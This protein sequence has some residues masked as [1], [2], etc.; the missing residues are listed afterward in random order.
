MNTLDSFRCLE[1]AHFARGTGDFG[2]LVQDQLIFQNICFVV[3][4]LISHVAIIIMK[5]GAIISF[6]FACPTLP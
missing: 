1:L 6:F 3:K 5:T 2:H 4:T